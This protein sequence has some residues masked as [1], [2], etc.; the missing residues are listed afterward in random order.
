MVDK[1]LVQDC[2]CKGTSIVYNRFEI[3][4]TLILI[5]NLLLPLFHLLALFLTWLQFLR[6]L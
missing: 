6:H 5:G 2:V 4:K 3:L 1:N